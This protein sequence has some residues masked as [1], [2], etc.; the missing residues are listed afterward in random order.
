MIKNSI[1]ITILT[2]GLLSSL[3]SVEAASPTISIS[4]TGDGNTVTVN[5]ANADGNS[6]VVLFYK[7]ALYTGTQSTTIGSTNSTGV[8]SGN[9]STSAYGIT[10]NT[11]IYALING[12]QTPYVTWPYNTSLNTSSNPVTFSQTNPTI[13]QGQ[14]LALTIN[15]SSGSYYIL[16]NNNQTVVKSDISGNIL[17]ITGLQAGSGNVTVCSSNGTCS[18]QVITVTNSSQTTSSLYV[19]QSNITV[20]VGQTS[21]VVVTGGTAP[22]SIF[23][24]GTNKISASVSGTIVSVTGIALGNTSVTVCGVTGGCTPVS[25][26]VVQSNTTTSPVAINVP[27]SVG[28]TIVMPLSGGNGAYYI[29]TPITT[30][31]SATI[32]GSNLRI[33]GTA[34]GN[35]MVTVCST[36]TACATISVAVSAAAVITTTTQTSTQ[37]SKYIF[38]NPL[39]SGMSGDE[40]F[41]LQERLAEEGYLYA[42]PNGYYG[43][44]TIAAVKAFQRDNKLSQLGNVGPGTRAA[45]NK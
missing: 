36:T 28:Q 17:S 43:P 7:T 37:S 5:I 4:P 32:S 16:S 38:E 24:D 45:L 11:Q 6:P 34:T 27:V 8:F 15:G 19:T 26:T 9:V 20:T 31:F 29:S 22:Y 41:K 3:V 1:K 12:Y 14:T 2:L 39:Y 25:V 21:Q 23:Y 40:V 42:T 44:A 10:N 35:N 33:L 13:I 30:P 18:T